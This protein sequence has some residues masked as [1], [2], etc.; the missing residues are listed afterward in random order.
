MHEK[1]KDEEEG[2]HKP[3]FILFADRA[4]DVKCS[5]CKNV[6]LCLRDV[7]KLSCL[8]KCVAIE[9]AFSNQNVQSCPSTKCSLRSK[10]EY[11]RQH[12]L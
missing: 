6:A 7:I 12:L 10:I 4:C 2:G 5:I 9:S 11:K 1:S 3:I 8:A